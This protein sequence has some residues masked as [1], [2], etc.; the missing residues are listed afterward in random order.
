MYVFGYECVCVCEC[1]YMCVCVYICVFMLTIRPPKL[2][3]VLRVKPGRA[4]Y[5]RIGIRESS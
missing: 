4:E 2:V 3:C 1:V 5:L